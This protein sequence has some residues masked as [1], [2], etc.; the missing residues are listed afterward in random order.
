[1]SDFN[2]KPDYEEKRLAA[3][4]SYD[5]ANTISETEYNDIA[6]LASAICGTPVSLVTFV[7]ENWQW[8]KAK[9]GTDIEGTPRAIAFC[10]H[11]IRVADEVMI[12]EDASADPRFADNPLV[13]QDPNIRFYAGAPF[14][15]DEGYT[16]GTVCVLDVVPRKLSAQQA[17]SLQILSRQVSELLRTRRIN[18]NLDQA[19]EF[20]KGRNKII[21][22]ELQVLTAERIIEMSA[23]NK[24]LERINKELEAFA[25]ISSHDL[26]E[27]LRKIQTFTSWL[28][29]K[30]MDGLSGRGKEYLLKIGGSAGR[31]QQLIQDLLQYS[32][33][34][35]STRNFEETTLRE[36]ITPVL[37]DLEEEI[38]QKNAFIEIHGDGRMFVI[39][40]QLR[41]LLHNLLSNA[42]KFTKPGTDP[43]IRI[44]LFYEAEHPNHAP[45]F[46]IEFSDNGIGFDNQYSDRIFTLFQRLSSEQKVAGTGIGLTIVR[47]IVNNHGGSVE[48]QG[49]EN[50]GAVFTVRIPDQNVK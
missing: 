11:S 6:K 19:N 29:E 25:Y 32:R 4:H 42:L 18:L 34:A 47:Q 37:E 22:G 5:I 3:L 50:E 9:M 43:N 26:Q 14:T 49:K 28:V 13:T 45:C 21:D 39:K 24:E 8:F 40:Y 7:D 38:S 48:A 12:V 16:L 17:E 46:R 44:A 1:M 35:M 27:P 36:T 2:E 31:M 30:E 10:E 41:Q 20:L 23:K 15:N 33:I